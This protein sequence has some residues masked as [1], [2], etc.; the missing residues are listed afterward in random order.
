MVTQLK[1]KTLTLSDLVTRFRHSR[2]YLSPQSQDYYEAC[3][4]GLEWFARENDWPA[5]LEEIT[6]AHIRT[7]LDYVADEPHRWVG[8]GRRATKKQASSGTVHH[9]GKTVKTLFGWAE[10]EEYLVINPVARLKLG[11]PHYKEVEPYSDEQVMAI[12]KVCENDARTRRRRNCVSSQ[13]T[14]YLG[15]R[16]KAIISL[17][18]ST[19]LRQEELTGI[20]LSDLDPRLQQIR[21]MGKGAKLRVVPLDGEARRALRDYLEIRQR[22]GDDLWKTD[23]GQP[24]ANYA[25]KTTIARL[26][27]R[28]GI[29]EGGGAHRFRHFFATRYLDAGGDINAL[30]LLLGHSTLSMVL[31]YSKHANVQRALDRHHEFNPLDRLYHGGRKRNRDNGQPDEE[32]GWKP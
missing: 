31:R 12:L 24:M 16:N 4:F 10:E 8:S 27:R 30:R 19:G 18:V 1:A 13:G 26:K 6:R 22:G 15:I 25:V 32:W 23:D 2:R 11:P 17:F 9:Y 7:F 20:G 3:L 29:T 14:N 28:A 5:P 21:I